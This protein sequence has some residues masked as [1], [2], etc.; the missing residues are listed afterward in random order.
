MGENHFTK[1]RSRCLSQNK[2]SAPQ[3]LRDREAG[4]IDRH[5]QSR[6]LV[7]PLLHGI[8][9]AVVWHE[10]FTR[11]LKLLVCARRAA[12]SPPLQAEPVL[13][14]TAAVGV[15]VQSPESLSL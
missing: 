2:Y 10:L 5:H 6:L 8:A 14:G 9:E 13:D 4:G 7:A 15:A 3:L 12:S 11:R 1:D